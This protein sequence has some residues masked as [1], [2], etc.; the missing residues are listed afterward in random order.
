MDF[1]WSKRENVFNEELTFNYNVNKPCDTLRIAAVDA[2]R[3][4]FDNKLISYGPERTLKGYARLREIAIPLGVKV[5]TVKVVSYGLAILTCAYQSPF[6]GAEILC[7][8]NVVDGTGAFSCSVDMKKLRSVQKYSSQRGFLEVYD[9][10]RDYFESVETVKV[11]A[12]ILI[13]GLGDKCRYFE[14]ELS[15]IGKSV[16]NGFYK[17]DKLWWESNAEKK[18]GVT[19]YIV[20]RDMLDT[21]NGLTALDF[22]LDGIKTGFFKL[23]VKTAT[24][25]RVIAVFEEIQPDGNWIFRRSCCNDYLEWNLPKGEYELLSAEPYTFKFVKILTDADIEVSIS[26]VKLQNDDENCVQFSGGGVLK[27]IYDSAVNSFRQNALDIFMDCPGRER[28]GW[29]CDSYFTG[30]TENFFTGKN[31]IEKNFLENYLLI[32]TANQDK[33][34]L[35]MCFPS[36]AGETFIPNWVMWFVLELLEYYKRTGDGALIEKAK[37]K[38]Y[39]IVNYFNS[40]RNELGLL[41]NLESWVFVEWSICNNAEY[42][43]GV[44]F[45]SNMLYAKMLETVDALYGDI[46]LKEQAKMLKDAIIKV[47]FDGNYFAD[48]AVRV[49]GK[50]TRCDDHL[51]E[52]CQYYAL[53]TKT[54]CDSIYT[55]KII[56]EFGP[57]NPVK[58]NIG[59]SNVFIGYYLRFMILKEMNDYDRIID[60]AVKLFA[61]MAKETKTLW[62]NDSPSASCNHGFASVIACLITESVIKSDKKRGV[63]IKFNYGKG[64]EIFRR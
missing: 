42:V 4:F 18:I 19:D 64:E 14:E 46:E 24:K 12:P 8:N 50:L 6:F 20:K 63:E 40:F 53:F 30:I 29:L 31:E 56:D 34:H 26:V 37:E 23:K 2:Y 61:P 33:V 43:K 45:P 32:D 1:I 36:S 49:D 59:K 51:S 3:V 25:A 22:S 16:F 58:E 15:F 54:I 41:E 52:T 5:I 62:E 10:S 44:N 35:P 17:I 7:G 21:I 11:S 27:E 48:N 55:A 13:D 38:V 47:S 39:K 28:A 60:E 9:Y 57:L